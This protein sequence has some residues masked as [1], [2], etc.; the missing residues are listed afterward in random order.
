MSELFDSEF[1]VLAVAPVI[2]G[3]HT[4]QCTLR[5]LHTRI[6]CGLRSRDCA[7]CGEPVCTLYLSIYC[8]IVIENEIVIETGCT[9]R[10]NKTP[11]FSDIDAFTAII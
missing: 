9:P 6:R 10:M 2:G 1:A 5:L 11:P 7:V 8:Y 4:R 3:S